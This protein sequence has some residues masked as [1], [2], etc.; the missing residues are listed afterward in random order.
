MYFPKV[1]FTHIISYC[2]DTIEQKQRKLWNSIK[3]KQRDF[4]YDDDCNLLETSP[5]YGGENITYY[6][7]ERHCPSDDVITGF[8]QNW[9]LYGGGVLHETPGDG[10]CVTISGNNN[11]VIFGRQVF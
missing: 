9:N 5:G 7:T 8:I 2:D 11:S 3:V 1:I 6:Y 10:V 4:T